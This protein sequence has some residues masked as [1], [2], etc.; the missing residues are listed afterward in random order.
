LQ[1]MWKVIPITYTLRYI[2]DPC[3]D[4]EFHI[5][6]AGAVWCRTIPKRHSYFFFLF[7]HRK[8]E[9]Q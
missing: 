9:A 1:D 3:K 6:G 7:F 2:T 5:A 8:C 4:S